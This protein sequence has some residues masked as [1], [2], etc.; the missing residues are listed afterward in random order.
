M[1]RTIFFLIKAA[2]VLSALGWVAAQGG[3]LHLEWGG[4]SFDTTPAIALA[5]LGL[6]VFFLSAVLRLWHAFIDLP[7][8]YRRYIISRRRETGYK[9][10]TEGLVAVAAGDYDTATRALKR[11]QNT[12]P[13]A[14]L[15]LLL[16]AQTALMG[17]NAP[18][19][20]RDFMALLDSGDTAFFGLRGLLTQ[21]LREGNAEETLALARRA[22]KL[23]P[24][25][26]WVLRTLY[27]AE[28]RTQNWL[29][30]LSTLKR[31][32]RI[33]VFDKTAASHERKA[34]YA[35]LS[36]DA[37]AA[38]NDS[39]TLRYA[40]MSLREDAGFTPAVI[41]AARAAFAAD[42]R[43]RALAILAAGWKQA[44]HPD[45]A[46][47]WMEWLP[48]EKPSKK[49]ISPYDEAQRIFGWAAELAAENAGHRESQRLLGQT[50]LQ[51][52]LYREARQ[53]LTEARDYRQLARLELAESQNDAKARAWL[54]KLEETPAADM[55]WACTSC[56]H[57]PATWAPL[58]PHCS[59][60]NTIDWV[61]AR[62][63]SEG[64]RHPPAQLAGFSD[65]LFDPP[66]W[67][68]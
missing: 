58:C 61:I 52:K 24:R 23:Q 53:H 11:A 62:A 26:P 60:F 37:R 38:A 33:G 56:G 67:E 39:D 12:V 41:L 49:P 32:E 45:I 25:R 3:T 46:A 59:Q 55:G 54:E 63:A 42:K 28:T 51:Q 68:K 30:A 48:V 66:V 16:S 19:A 31:A 18:K 1:L 40:D 34:L 14:P 29:S 64:H 44:P 13:Q 35:A 7:Q 2:L 9:A 50:A 43:K 10:I 4:R 15:A 21:S 27:D 8:V 47:L 65:G 20:R 22:E 5:L 6:L 57:I 36:M 17:G